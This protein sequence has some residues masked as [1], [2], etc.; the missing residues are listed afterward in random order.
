MQKLIEKRF[1]KRIQKK[2]RTIFEKGLLQAG[3]Q[4]LDIIRTKTKKG[5]D[6]RDVPFK[7]YSQ[8]YLKKLKERENQQ[9]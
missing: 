9:K 8:E 3:F 2:F 4:L 6:F 5:I 1:I 7:P